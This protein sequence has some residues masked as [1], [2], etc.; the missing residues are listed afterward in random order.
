MVLLVDLGN[1]L[2][3]GRLEIHGL[4]MI[5]CL[6]FDIFGEPCDMNTLGYLN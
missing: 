1:T 2:E 6:A 4:P 5:E 3:D